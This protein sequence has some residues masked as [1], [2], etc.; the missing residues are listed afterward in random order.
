LSFQ[1]LSLKPKNSEA[2][3]EK[4]DSTTTRVMLY[5]SGFIVKPDTL[6]GEL[7]S[8]AIQK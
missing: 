2:V 7:S 8:C 5:S 6:L 1:S 3:D 4:A